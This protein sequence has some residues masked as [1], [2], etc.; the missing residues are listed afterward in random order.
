MAD[1]EK[2]S[3]AMKQ[4][5]AAIAA[6]DSTAVAV[7]LLMKQFNVKELD[8]NRP[9]TDAD[10]ISILTLPGFQQIEWKSLVIPLEMGQIKMD[11]TFQFAV[12]EGDKLYLLLNQ[13]KQFKRSAATYKKLIGALLEIGCGEAAESV[14]KLIPSTELPSILVP[15]PTTASK[16]TV[17]QHHCTLLDTHSLY[18]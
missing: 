6:K 12:G 17:P 8:C 1:S 18:T 2:I 9:V 16:V 14:C 4:F 10:I 11:E 15:A 3:S 13:W 7:D 5:I